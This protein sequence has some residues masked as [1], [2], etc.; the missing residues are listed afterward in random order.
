[1]IPAYREI[2]FKNKDVRT[3]AIEEILKDKKDWVRD[4]RQCYQ[5][6]R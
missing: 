4:I 2:S 3:D 6:V 1:M 5:S